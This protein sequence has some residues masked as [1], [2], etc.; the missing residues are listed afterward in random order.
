MNSFS[1][2]GINTIS[3]IIGSP[4]NSSSTSYYN[5]PNHQALSSVSSNYDG[6]SRA[7]PIQSSN[8]S[9]RPIRNQSTSARSTPNLPTSTPIH[10]IHSPMYSTQSNQP[11]TLDIQNGRAKQNYYD[12][13][14]PSPAS[15]SQAATSVNY[16][17]KMSNSTP[18]QNPTLLS[19]ST[20]SSTSAASITACR[21]A[22]TGSSSRQTSPLSP[23]PYNNQSSTSHLAMVEEKFSGRGITRSSASYG[24]QKLLEEQVYHF[25]YVNRMYS[26]W[27]TK[28]PN[29]NLMSSFF[30]N[31]QN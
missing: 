10:N 6:Q 4:S 3:S 7:T 2:I 1:T 26:G 9:R 29:H 18:Y 13:N 17:P 23:P 31:F 21:D 14:I 12:N 28:I 30:F 24:I 22:F 16:N 20:I 11:I 27:P 19:T 5:T 8:P 15:S 25:N